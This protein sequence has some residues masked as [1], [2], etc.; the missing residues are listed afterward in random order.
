MTMSTRP[1]KATQK[2][3]VSV[4]KDKNKKKKKERI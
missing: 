1:A 4:K 2:D 3:Q